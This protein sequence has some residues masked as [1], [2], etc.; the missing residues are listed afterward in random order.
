[1]DIVNVVD[2]AKASA[3][4]VPVG[5][6]ATVTVLKEQV[7]WIARVPVP[8]DVDT[9]LKLFLPV[10]SRVVTTT[11]ELVVV[12]V[13]FEDAAPLDAARSRVPTV[14]VPVPSVRLRTLVLLERNEV[15]VKL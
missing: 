11:D 7:P 13:R 3:I 14:Q 1:M 6:E 8:V 2:A 4:L 5:A 12:R 9:L 10:L 15:A